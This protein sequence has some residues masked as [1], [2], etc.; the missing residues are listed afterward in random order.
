MDLHEIGQLLPSESCKLQAP[1]N[2]VFK[3]VFRLYNDFRDL[4]T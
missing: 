2:E 1:E 4:V 3:Q